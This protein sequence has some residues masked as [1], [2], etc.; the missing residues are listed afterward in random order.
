MIEFYFS[1]HHQNGT[2]S[3]LKQRIS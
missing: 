2:Q 3:H 1:T